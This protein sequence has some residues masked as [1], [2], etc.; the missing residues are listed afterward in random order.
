[1]PEQTGTPAK[2]KNYTYYLDWMNEQLKIKE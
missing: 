2:D 1:M